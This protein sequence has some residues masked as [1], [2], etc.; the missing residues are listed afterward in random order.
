MRLEILQNGIKYYEGMDDGHGLEHIKQVMINMIKLIDIVEKGEDI[1][2]NKELMLTAVLYHDSGN[3]IDR[4]E[5]HLIAGQTVRSEEYL[6]EIFTEEE[7]ELIATM[8]EEHRSSK[9]EECT[10]LMSAMLNDADSINTFENM[11]ERAYKYHMKHDENKEYEFIFGRVYGHLK[12]KFGRNGY[13]RYRTQYTNELV[14]I[15]ERYRIL[16]N[17]KEFRKVFDKIAGKR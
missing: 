7:I 12:E 13:H 4:K 15:E 5:H 8:C 1:K 2:L 9:K 10:S 16:E 14:N 3:K 17:E 6:K 11:V